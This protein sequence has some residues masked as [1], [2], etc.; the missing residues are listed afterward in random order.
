MF[1]KCICHC[2]C[3]CICLRCCLF[4]GQIMSPHHSDHISQKS[5]VSR[6]APKSNCVYHCHCHWQQQADLRIVLISQHL[7]LIFSLDKYIACLHLKSVMQLFMSKFLTSIK[8]SDFCK[9]EAWS[10]NIVHF[11][12]RPL[13]I[14]PID[15]YCVHLKKIQPPQTQTNINLFPSLTH[16]LHYLSMFLTGYCVDSLKSNKTIKRRVFPDFL[17]SV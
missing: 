8:G 7:C 15:H 11:S 13:P 1:S 5:Q 17:D 16:Y 12:S 3:L 10:S 9:D 14:S 6:I 2:H 4:V